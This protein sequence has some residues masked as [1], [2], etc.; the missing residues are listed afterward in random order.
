MALVPFDLTLQQ[1]TR[2]KVSLKVYANASAN[3]DYRG[4][5]SA[6]ASALLD[7]SFSI[8]GGAPA[9]ASFLYSAGVTA[10]PEPASWA[11]LIAGL[12]C[13]GGAAR[14]RCG[15]LSSAQRAS[16]PTA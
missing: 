14:R 7:P 8:V 10:V 9:G 2:Y 6:S 16:L 12:A 4:T 1:N 15:P 5:S 13:F 3:Y 11:L